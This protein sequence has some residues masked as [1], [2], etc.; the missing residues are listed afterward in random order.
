M[1]G[2]ASQGYFSHLCWKATGGTLSRPEEDVGLDDSSEIL[3]DRRYRHTLEI[4]STFCL[5]KLK[6]KT[7]NAKLDL[8]RDCLMTTQVDGNKVK[9]SRAWLN[10]SGEAG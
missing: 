7:G 8:N 5:M 10:Y 3:K 1:E 6:T 2:A 9:G 4:F